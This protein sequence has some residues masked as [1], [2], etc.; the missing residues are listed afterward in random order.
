MAAKVWDSTANGGKGDWVPADTPR[1]GTPPIP[2]PHRERRGRTEIRRAQLTI[3]LFIT[4]G[5]A[6][7]AAVVAIITGLPYERWTAKEF[8][9][10]VT[11]KFLCGPQKT[12]YCVSIVHDDGK[13]E[14]LQNHDSLW[15]WK[16]TSTDYQTLFQP[17]TRFHFKV[18]G[19]RWPLRS[20]FR[21]IIAAESIG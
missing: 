7:L 18:Y 1:R 6:V 9:A 3:A 2:D 14:V 17:D 15:W 10:T 21:N 5:F 12:V 11:E 19:W 20:W 13:A 4:V 8:N 16:W